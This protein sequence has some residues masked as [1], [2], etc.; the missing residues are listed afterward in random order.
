MGSVFVKSSHVKSLLLYLNSHKIFACLLWLLHVAV[1][2]C[3]WNGKICVFSVGFTLAE[4]WF[5]SNVKVFFVVFRSLLCNVV[6]LKGEYVLAFA[7]M[8][9][10]GMQYFYV[11][12]RFPTSLS[13]KT[14]PA[15]PSFLICKSFYVVKIYLM[16]LSL[17][18][19]SKDLK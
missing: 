10:L 1:S 7:L 5:L 15:K 14:Y 17:P 8:I 9:N 19:I 16:L 3:C 4:C 11:I 2:G 18:F 13:W 6:L 12:P